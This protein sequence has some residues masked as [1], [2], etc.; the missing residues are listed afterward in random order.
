VILKFQAAKVSG[1]VDARYAVSGR[2]ETVVELGV[3]APIVFSAKIPV[4]LVELAA[5]LRL[6]PV[7]L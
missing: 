2:A 4:F 3:G 7:A 1:R 5:K 6:R